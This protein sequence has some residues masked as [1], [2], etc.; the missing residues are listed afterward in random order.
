MDDNNDTTNACFD[1]SSFNSANSLT[2]LLDEDPNDFRVL[3]CQNILTWK[4]L[5]NNY[6]AQKQIKYFISEYTNYKY[7]V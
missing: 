6:P 1:N 2:H 4:L 3:L 5:V 7:K